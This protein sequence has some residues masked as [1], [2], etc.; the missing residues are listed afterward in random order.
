MNFDRWSHMTNTPYVLT[1]M[2][3]FTFYAMFD[4]IYYTKY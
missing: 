4:H 2:L 1:L 3:L